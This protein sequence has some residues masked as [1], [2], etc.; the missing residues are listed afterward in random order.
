MCKLLILKALYACL[1]NVQSSPKKRDL[2]RTSVQQRFFHMSRKF[3]YIFALLNAI[4]W[5]K[6]LDF[7]KFLTKEFINKVPNILNSF[8][9]GQKMSLFIE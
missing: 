6:V 9:F 3:S 2:K 4:S 7:N 1:Q 5:K 8:R